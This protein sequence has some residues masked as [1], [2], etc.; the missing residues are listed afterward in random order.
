LVRRPRKNPTKTK[1]AK[2]DEFEVPFDLIV[3]N[4]FG[5]GPG[6]YARA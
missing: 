5:G 1:K 3:A 2:N 6:V 4:G